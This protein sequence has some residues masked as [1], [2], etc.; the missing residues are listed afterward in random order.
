[1]QF[2]NLQDFIAMDGHGFY[3]WLCY[4]FC[5]VIF[6]LLSYS[7]VSG[8]KSTKARIKKRY[9]RDLKL[10]RAAEKQAQE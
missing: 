6:A 2:S 7:T 1:M 10:K 5:L 9:E 4:G 8:Q 3:V